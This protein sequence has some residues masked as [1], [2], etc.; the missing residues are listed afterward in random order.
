MMRGVQQYGIRAGRITRLAVFVT[1]AAACVWAASAGTV[2][3]SQQYRL[4][5]SGPAALAG[6]ATSPAHSLDGVGGNGMANGI[7]A[8]A[9]TSIVSGNAA[10]QLP[11]D[12]IFGDGYGP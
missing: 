9:N 7:A 11:T 5:G 4:Y 12:R 6:R 8:S 2:P 3:G 1:L 10:S